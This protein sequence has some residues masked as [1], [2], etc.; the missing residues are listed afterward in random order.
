MRK[1]YCI[2]LRDSAAVLDITILLKSGAE[3]LFSVKVHIAVDISTF[4]H[5]YFILGLSTFNKAC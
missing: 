5:F 2:I 3:L 1:K 4:L